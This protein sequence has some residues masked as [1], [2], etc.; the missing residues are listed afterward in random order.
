M[1][2]QMASKLRDLAST[3]YYRAI[4]NKIYGYKNGSRVQAK[5]CWYLGYSKECFHWRTIGGKSR[6]LLYVLL[7]VYIWMSSD[8]FS[9]KIS[10][11]CKY[12][13]F[14]LVL[15]L[16]ESS[17]IFGFYRN[18]VSLLTEN[19]LHFYNFFSFLPYE[20]SGPKFLYQLWFRFV[21]IIS[22][23]MKETYKCSKCSKIALNIY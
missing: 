19:S 12:I 13:S 23:S 15:C 21:L 6:V 7:T 5:S 11:P 18:C 20:Q 2:L 16:K 3:V 17:F 9:G 10:G 14:C 8:F 1:I 22:L 4:S